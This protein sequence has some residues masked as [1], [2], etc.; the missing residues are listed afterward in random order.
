MKEILSTNFDLNVNNVNA[1]TFYGDGTNITGVESVPYY[2]WVGLIKVTDTTSQ[3]IKIQGDDYFGDLSI[4][5]PYSATDGVD[6]TSSNGSI[7]TNNKTFFRSPNFLYPSSI[8]LGTTATITETTITLKLGNNNLSV[9]SGSDGLFS[10]F[11]IKVF[12]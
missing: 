4:T 12:K 10:S 2:S 5:Q 11:E 9:P 7:F 6:I 1:V 3:L 8:A